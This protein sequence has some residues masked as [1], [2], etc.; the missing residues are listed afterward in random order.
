MSTPTKPQPKKRPKPAPVP[1]TAYEIAERTLAAS[2][3]V[4]PP[5]LPNERVE[6]H[7]DDLREL[8]CQAV[9]LARQEWNM[10]RPTDL[11]PDDDFTDFFLREHMRDVGRITY[12][13]EGTD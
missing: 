10:Q 11:L 3:A 6:L 5:F 12:L 4:H 7:V 8:L 13:N 2:D 9:D 1:L